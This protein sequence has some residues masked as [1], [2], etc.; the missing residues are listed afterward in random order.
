VQAHFGQ[1]IH[2]GLCQVLVGAAFDA[3]ALKQYLTP[4]AAREQATLERLCHTLDTAITDARRLAR[5]LFPVQLEQGGLVAALR[6]LT[7][8]VGQHAGLRVRFTEAGGPVLVQHHS[9]AMHLFRLAQEALTNA[10]KH[11]RAHHAWVRLVLARRSLTLSIA[12]DGT[13]LPPG[14]QEGGGLGLHVMEYRARALGGTL[15]IR[16]RAGGGTEVRCRLPWPPTVA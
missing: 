1:E 4:V 10:A 8:A 5:G 15:E 16:P 6:E 12:D 11:A 3:N 2:D 9:T 13:G 14:A 7:S